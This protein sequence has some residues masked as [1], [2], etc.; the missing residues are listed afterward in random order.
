MRAERG[1]ERVVDR[2]MKKKREGR[3]SSATG[4]LVNE[5]D[6]IFPCVGAAQEVAVTK[7]IRVKRNGANER[8]SRS[9]EGY[10]A[11]HAIGGRPEREK[12]LY[13]VGV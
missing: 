4:D 3:V 6:F 5:K 10:L 2:W 12:A 11:F 9:D 1:E 7:Q 13:H 8:K